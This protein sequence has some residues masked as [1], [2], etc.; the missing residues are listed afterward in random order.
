MRKILSALL[1]TALALPLSAAEKDAEGLPYYLPKTVV[2]VS[3]LIEK[4]TFTP[5][6]LA[7]YSDIYFKTTASDQPSET[8]R[9]VG[10]SFHTTA[11]PDSTKLFR[12]PM[13][14]KHTILNVACD[15]NGVLKAINA[16]GIDVE[17]PQPF[18]PARKPRQLSPNDYMSQDILSS[19]NLPRMARMVAQEIYD[20]RDSRNQLSRGEADFMP[21][22]GEQMK[23]MLGQ[24]NTQETALMQLFEGTTV[25]DTTETTLTYIPEKGKEREVLFRFSKHFGLVDAD[26]LSGEPYYVTATDQHVVPTLPTGTVDDQ[27]KK[28][29][30]NVGV[31]LPGRVKVAVSHKA[32]TVASFETEAAQFGRVETLSESLFTK[33]MTAHVVVNPVTGTVVSL[34]SEP[35]E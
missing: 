20:I 31:S 30:F 22:D 13:D 10:Y 12:V 26:D 5:G 4:T 17:K 15:N 32:Q 25:K 35:L 23:L 8:Y 24:L 1:S 21:K 6:Q 14:K 33:K 18:V 28:G 7:L 9:I 16:K 19:G 27:K 11:L 29:E 34:E 2:H 3:L